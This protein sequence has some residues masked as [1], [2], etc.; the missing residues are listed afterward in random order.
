MQIGRARSRRGPTSASPLPERAPEHRVRSEPAPGGSPRRA[1][2]RVSSSRARRRASRRAGRRPRRCRI[3]AD[4]DPRPDEP[5]RAARD[6]R[7]TREARRPSGRCRAMKPRCRQPAS[8]LVAAAR[9]R[10]GHGHARRVTRWAPSTRRAAISDLRTS[11]ALL[12]HLLGRDDRELGEHRHALT[13]ARDQAVEVPVEPA[14][15]AVPAVD[16]VLALG[17]PV[18]LA[19]VDDELRLAARPR[20]ARCRTRSPAATGV[21]RSSPPCRISVGVVHR[22]A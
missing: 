2:K 5:G 19:R 21:Q 11:L 9:R 18:A 17:P 16:L 7:G 8:R 20:R 12:D 3:A 10:L 22:C 14:A 13:L 4:D 1:R 6:R 15:D